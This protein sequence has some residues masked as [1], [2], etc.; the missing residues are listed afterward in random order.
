MAIFAFLHGHWGLTRKIRVW[1]EA[2]EVGREFGESILILTGEAD[3]NQVYLSKVPLS[4][5]PDFSFSKVAC[6]IRISKRF[7]HSA[8]VDRRSVSETLGKCIKSSPCDSED[9]GG[10]S[11]FWIL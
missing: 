10:Y 8:Q 4:F 5:T 6:T 9:P 11:S 2:V 1:D 3:S 7:A